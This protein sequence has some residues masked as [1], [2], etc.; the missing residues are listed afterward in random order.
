MIF[1]YNIVSNEK[2]IYCNCGSPHF[3][4]ELKV[5]G[6]ITGNQTIPRYNKVSKALAMLLPSTQAITRFQNG[7][8]L[9]NLS[10]LLILPR[11][12]L[13]YISV[14]HLSS[15]ILSWMVS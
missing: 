12:V 8:N 1:C 6:R 7:E 2:C 14:F 13:N 15:R 3:G 10:L 4:T 9:Q 5:S 11:S